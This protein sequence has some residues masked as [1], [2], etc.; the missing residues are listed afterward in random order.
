M[1]ASARQHTVTKV[2]GSFLYSRA[3]RTIAELAGLLDIIL[4]LSDCHLSPAKVKEAITFLF[5]PGMI[6]SVA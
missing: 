2:F 3:R 6:L 4:L 5:R 1:E